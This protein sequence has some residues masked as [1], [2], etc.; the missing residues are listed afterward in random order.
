MNSRS[1]SSGVGGGA[2]GAGGRP[3]WPGT[4]IL[5]GCWLMGSN[6][7]LPSCPRRGARVSGRGGGSAGCLLLLP[8]LARALLV[9]LERLQHLLLRAVGDDLAGVEHDDA[10]D[11]REQA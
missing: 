1:A 6:G 4:G 2:L 7:R 11:Q 10:L 3:G 8:L 5:A 9:R